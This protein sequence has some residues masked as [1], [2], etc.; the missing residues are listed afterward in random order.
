MKVFCNIVNSV[1]RSI[2]PYD[3]TI[4]MQITAS[5]QTLKTFVNSSAK[6]NYYEVFPDK[7]F[8]TLLG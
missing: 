8:V 1:G 5:L 4:S 2:F 7:F 6:F 3:M